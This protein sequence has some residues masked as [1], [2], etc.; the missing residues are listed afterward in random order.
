MIIGHCILLMTRLSIL[1]ST[2][3][4]GRNAL[5]IVEQFPDRFSVLAL[6][7]G[8]NIKLL[9]KQI[10]RFRPRIG[11]VMDDVLARCLQQELGSSNHVEI[12]YG[13]YG[14]RTAA[15]LASADVVVSAMV[16]ASGLLPTLAAIET[17]KTVA[18]ANKESLVMAG[19]LLMKIARAQGSHVIPVDSEHSAIFQ[20]LRGHRRQELKQ[21]LLTASGGPFLRKKTEELEKIT[22]EMAL[23]HPTWEMGAKVTIDSATLMNKGLEIIEARWLFDVPL[24]RIKV[25]IHPESIIHSMVVYHDGSVIGQLAVT[26]MRIPIAYAMSYPE[27]LPLGLDPP[28]FVDLGALSFQEPDMERF[29]CLKLA[30]EACRQGGTF[31]AVLSAANEVA[32]NAFLNHRI[33]FG[34]IAGITEAVMNQH[35]P[36]SKPGLSDILQA[37]A[38]ARQIAEE[39][40]RV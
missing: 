40:I 28:D 1:G 13:E 8:K 5:R 30:I 19:E 32:V 23:C 26:D 25:L 29:P 37:D 7:G 35:T 3:S 4:I 18:L 14:Y 22:P 9:C 12:L 10:K 24:D 2:G 33:G 31:P 15:T 11:V 17:G 6:A 39:N 34:Q 38:W 36:A 20:S 16:G 21:I 27:R